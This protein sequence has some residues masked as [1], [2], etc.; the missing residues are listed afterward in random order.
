LDIIPVGSIPT[1]NYLNLRLGNV[2]ELIDFEVPSRC[3]PRS[4]RPTNFISLK[5]F[6]FF[7][8]FRPDVIPKVADLQYKKRNE[9]LVDIS[10]KKIKEIKEL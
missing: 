6:I 8:K 5:I 2:Q 1:N 3:N 9:I 7:S 4:R 10:L